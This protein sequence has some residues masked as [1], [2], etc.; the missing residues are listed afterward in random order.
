[1][2]RIAVIAGDGVGPE[3]IPQGVR[4]LEVL[5]A[6][7]GLGLVL[8]PWPYGADHFLATGETLPEARFEALLRGEYAAVLLGAVGDPRLPDHRH[9]RDI[10]LGLRTRLDLYVNL[11]PVR[12]LDDRLTPLKGKTRREVDLVVFRENTEGLYTGAGGRVRPGTPEEV[13]L[14]QDVNTARGVTRILRAALDFAHAHGKRR[15]CMSDKS[16]A[17]THAGALWQ[18]LWRELGEGYPELERRHLYVDALCLELVRAPEQFD[19]VVTSNLFGDVASDVGA[20]IAGGMGVA[21][22]ANLNPESGLG[23]FEPVHGSAPGLAGKDLAN[24]C[25]TFLTCALLL[26]HLGHPAEARLLEAAVERA[27]R[28]GRLTPDCGGALGTRAVADFVVEELART[29]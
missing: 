13:A 9:A 18:R 4:A 6:R 28:E 10:L 16:N 1:M 17:M 19:V 11:R 20:A 25:A 29:A 3:V 23:L 12:L 8:E 7:R 21:A 22:S 26:E 5:S 14:E 27:A 2:A 24:P 15:V